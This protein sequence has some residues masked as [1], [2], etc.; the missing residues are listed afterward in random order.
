[1]VRVSETSMLK[2]SVLLRNSERKDNPI[3]DSL[4]ILAALNW[5]IS[6]RDAYFSTGIF[7]ETVITDSPLLESTAKGATVSA[8]LSRSLGISPS[9]QIKYD[10]REFTKWAGG[11]NRRADKSVSAEF[12][13][14]FTNIDYFGFSPVLN[15]G[16]RKVSSNVDIFDREGA[17]VGLTVKSRF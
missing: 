10:Q 8:I 15:F 6:S 13:F 2:S 12:A 11:A 17:T 7:F 16:Y 5:Q 14:D 9:A 4:S 1:M 3:N